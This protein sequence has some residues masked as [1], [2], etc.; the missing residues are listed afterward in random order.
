M[1]VSM[2]GATGMVAMA[3]AMPLLGVLWPVMALAIALFCT[4]QLFNVQATMA[5]KPNK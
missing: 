5:T 3:M 4:M 2:G 1:L